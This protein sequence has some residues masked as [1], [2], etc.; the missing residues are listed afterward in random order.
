MGL[1]W[2]D[3]PRWPLEKVAWKKNSKLKEN[4]GDGY[5]SD[6]SCVLGHFNKVKPKLKENV[7]SWKCV[8]VHFIGSKKH[9]YISL[10]AREDRAVSLFGGNPEGNTVVE[11]KF[12]VAGDICL[13][14]V[15][16]MSHSVS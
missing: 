12:C 4:G 6:T 10:T 13:K 8:P 3:S 5:R 14:H 7:F 2:L 1:P 9:R 15:R 16:H 11:F